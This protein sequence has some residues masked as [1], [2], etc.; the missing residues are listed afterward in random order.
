MVHCFSGVSFY[1]RIKMLQ[2]L[3]ASNIFCIKSG[4][5]WTELK[6]ESVME[7]WILGLLNYIFNRVFVLRYLSFPTQ[8][9]FGKTNR[10]IYLFNAKLPNHIFFSK[11]SQIPTNLVIRNSL[12]FNLPKS[13]EDVFVFCS[14][15]LLHWFN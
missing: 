12:L 5:I 10:N 14:Y 7:V 4:L 11:L 9:R 3:L 6:N 15:I 8:K 1:C 2:I 13:I